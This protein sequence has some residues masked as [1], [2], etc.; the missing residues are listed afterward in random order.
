MKQNSPILIAQLENANASI[1]LAL[2]EIKNV[3]VPR[4][5]GFEYLDKI[6]I[7]L[8]HSENVINNVIEQLK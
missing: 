5:T 1:N 2:S 4:V 6:T 3:V 8:K 7:L